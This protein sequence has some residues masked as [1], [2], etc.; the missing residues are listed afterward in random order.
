MYTCIRY[1]HNIAHQ[2]HIAYCHGGDGIY[3]VSVDVNSCLEFLFS[4][5]L[6]SVVL[7]PPKKESEEEEEGARTRRRRIRISGVISLDSQSDQSNNL[8][9]EVLFIDTHMFCFFL[10]G[11][12][13]VRPLN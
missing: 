4:S 7:S 13:I 11:F 9:V 3:Y 10:F 2:Q 1:I 12:L 8:V 5:A 6:A